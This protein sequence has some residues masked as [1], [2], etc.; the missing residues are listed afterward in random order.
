MNTGNHKSF[1]TVTGAVTFLTLLSMAAVAQAPE[2]MASRTRTRT[3][4]TEPGARMSGNRSVLAPLPG[5]ASSVSA[6]P[7]WNI[8]G[9]ETAPQ[10]TPAG[11]LRLTMQFTA[12]AGENVHFIVRVPALNQAQVIRVLVAG[13]GNQTSAERLVKIAAGQDAGYASFEMQ[14]PGQYEVRAG[15]AALMANDPN[16]VSARASFAVTEARSGENA[17]ELRFFVGYDGAETPRGFA[18][19]FPRGTDVYFQF[20]APQRV[21]APV[22]SFMVY[23][24]ATPGEE[25]QLVDQVSFPVRGTVL[26]LATQGGFRFEETGNYRVYVVR[27]QNT[28]DPADIRSARMVLARAD[29]RIQ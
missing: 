26:R 4:M 13:D 11:Q 3:N 17:G 16:A 8:T 5:L 25:E 29:L 21:T 28:D 15:D 1:L 27:D 2:Q 18:R 10:N 22:I 14:Q 6:A 20:L 23:R 7:G 12:G 24:V 9:A 19:T